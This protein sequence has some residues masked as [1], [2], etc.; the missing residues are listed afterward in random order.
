MFLMHSLVPRHYLEMILKSFLALS[1][2]VNSSMSWTPSGSILNVPQEID[3]EFRI[4]PDPDNCNVYYFLKVPMTCGE[5][6]AFNKASLRCDSLD[7]VA[8]M[9]SKQGKLEARTLHRAALR[10]ERARRGGAG[11]RA[12][13]G[14]RRVGGGW[15]AC[16]AW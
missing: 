4:S 6:N 7:N 9:L 2:L 10:G 15:G 5:G 12:G 16:G 1:L 14:G 8:N 3:I 11:W 13:A